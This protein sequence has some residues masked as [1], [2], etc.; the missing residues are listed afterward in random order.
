MNLRDASR[1]RALL[2]HYIYVGERVNDIFDT[3]PDRGE[4]NNF[5]AACDA[6][7]AYFT[8]EKNVSL[9]YLNFV[10]YSK[11]EVKASMNTK[12]A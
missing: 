6:L 9:K 3:L 2:L 7:T 1:E 11:L 5:K 8:P 4:D 12:H 10:N